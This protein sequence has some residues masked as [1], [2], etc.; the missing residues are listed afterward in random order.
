MVLNGAYF[1][2]W[3]IF[4]KAGQYEKSIA[5]YER[6]WLSHPDQGEIQLQMAKLYQKMENPKK[7]KEHY[8]L[9]L[10]Q[11][12]HWEEV[13][14]GL[15]EICYQE[16]QLE[17]AKTYFQRALDLHPHPETLVRLGM[18]CQELGYVKEAKASY[19]R[20]LEIKED[21]KIRYNVSCIFV[22]EGDLEKAQTYLE[23]L[24]SEEIPIPPFRVL[25][26]A[27]FIAENR[28]E[29]ETAEGFYRQACENDPQNPL[30]DITL[31]Q[32]LRKE[33]QLG[34]GIDLL[35][36]GLLH[37]LEKDELYYHLGL[38]Y[39]MLDRKKDAKEMWMQ[40][41][42]KTKNRNLITL[43]E[44]HQKEDAS[45]LFFQQERLAVGL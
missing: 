24:L 10:Q 44:A 25:A 30:G 27:G 3:T 2:K 20:V 6:V 32:F 9:L 16:K 41:I 31:A 23:P 5:A 34:K 18:V 29:K 26:L 4:L 12:P 1:Q 22:Q 14:R 19:Q 42:Q 37:C 45:I 35:K 36:E 43:I 15:G 40:S 8:Q 33:W 7:A 17:E 11:Y 13:Y 39:F 28:G 21:A 38:L